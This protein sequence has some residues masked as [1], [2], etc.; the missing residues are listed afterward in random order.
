MSGFVHGRHR[1]PTLLLY[2]KSPVVR[3]V[4]RPIFNGEDLILP[5]SRKRRVSIVNPVVTGGRK[6]NMD[7]DDWYDIGH[8]SCACKDDSIPQIYPPR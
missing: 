7:E 3:S 6:R 5:K 4:N 8:I 2:Q 1:I